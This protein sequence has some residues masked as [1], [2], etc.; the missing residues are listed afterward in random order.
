MN[1]FK[2]GSWF[3]ALA[4]SMP[5]A[6]VHSEESFTDSVETAFVDQGRISIKLSAGEHTITKSD[7]NTIRVSWRVRD[8]DIG[9]VDTHTEVDGSSA[10][11]DIDG[12]RKKFRTVIEVP[13]HTDLVVR[14]SAG[15][16]KIGNIEGDKDIRLRAG[17]LSID[18]GNADDYGDVQGSLWAGDIDAGPFNLEKSGLFRSIE[19]HG[20]GDHSL[21]FKLMAGDV[22]FYQV[23]N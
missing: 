17:D 23:Q 21:R 19:W 3:V 14:V 12:P 5:M 2:R 1:V 6:Q 15:E 22:T 13:R 10:K 16:V 8:E 4:L 11:I 18:V 9:Q 7:G 20:G